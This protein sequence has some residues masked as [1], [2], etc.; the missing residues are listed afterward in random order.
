MMGLFVP[1]AGL[2]AL[3]FEHLAAGSRRRAFSLG[4][5]LLIL[6]LPTTWLVLLSAQHGIQ[7]HEPLLYLTRSEQKALDWLGSN[8]PSDAL[9]LA[10]PD[11]GL[12]I[13]AQTGRRV[14]YG[15]PFET[16]NAEVEK[17][18]VTEY[19]RSGGENPPLTAQYPINYILVGPRER[20]LGNFLALTD[21]Q[22]VYQA[23]DVTIYA[24]DR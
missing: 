15:H 22:I 19:F 1:L 18:D 2:A 24:V 21:L 4:V 20:K 16:V 12:F 8:T 6:S 11:T 9:V 7:T 13:P 17:A 14:L 5:V 3:G 10:G 23:D